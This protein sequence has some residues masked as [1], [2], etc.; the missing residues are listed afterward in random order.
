MAVIR[1]E[2]RVDVDLTSYLQKNN[3]LTTPLSNM[4]RDVISGAKESCS[5]ESASGPIIDLLSV[6]THLHMLEKSLNGYAEAYL[7]SIGVSEPDP[8]IRAICTHSYGV[9]EDRP[10]EFLNFLF[11]RAS[12]KEPPLKTRILGVTSPLI[13]YH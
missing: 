5:Y 2:S 10:A 6:N 4:F 13:I 7:Q 8:R 9:Y 12:E 1:L 11:Y 3:L